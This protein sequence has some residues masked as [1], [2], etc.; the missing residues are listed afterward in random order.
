MH[1]IAYGTK[2][3]FRPFYH[4]NPVLARRNSLVYLFYRLR[5]H[6]NFTKRSLALKFG[7]SEDYLSRVEDGSR[8]PSLS[9]CLQCAIEF[10][11]NS[12]YVKNRWAMEAVQVFSERLHRRLKLEN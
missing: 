9:F 7:V 4:K 12:E 11:V 10:E 8:F 3:T 5:L 6:R 1:L 2:L